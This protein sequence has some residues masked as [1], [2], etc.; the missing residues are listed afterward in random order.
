MSQIDRRK[1]FALTSALVLAAACRSKGGGSA[2]SSSGAGSASVDPNRKVRLRL[3]YF[4]NVTHAQ[5]QVALARGSYQEA[6]GPN[7]TLDMS[8][9]FNAGPTAM[10]ALISG[11]I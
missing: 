2:G 9:S 3:G 1:F 5:P 10:E 7:V 8:R 4:P 6:L 11:S